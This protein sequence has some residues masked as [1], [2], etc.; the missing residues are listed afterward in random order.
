MSRS[1]FYTKKY[2]KSKKAPLNLN[3]VCYEDGELNLT[4][5]RLR[6]SGVFI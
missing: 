6:K 3:G 5:F 1:G 2:I 4:Y